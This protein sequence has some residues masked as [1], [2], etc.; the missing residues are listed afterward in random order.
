MIDCINGYVCA[1][2]TTGAPTATACN[3]F[4]PGATGCAAD[5]LCAIPTFA[6]TGT[7]CSVDGDDGV[8]DLDGFCLGI[9]VMH[10]RVGLLPDCSGLDGGDS[11]ACVA[12][13]GDT[14]YCQPLEAKGAGLLTDLS[15][16][17]A[18]DGSTGWIQVLVSACRLQIPALI[19]LVAIPQ[20]GWLRCRRLWDTKPQRLCGGWCSWRGCCGYA[21]RDQ[22]RW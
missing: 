1:D 17:A 19:A 10:W 13:A 14:A 18:A 9:R 5:A 8:D 12:V 7:V 22:R 21:V 16:N 15:D 3:P 2:P 20:L 4:A 11:S 6:A